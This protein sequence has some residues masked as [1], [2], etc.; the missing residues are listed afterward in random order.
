MIPGFENACKKSKFQSKIVQFTNL[1]GIIKMLTFGNRQ[2]RS[3]CLIK[4]GAKKIATNV[5]RLFIVIIV[6]HSLVSLGSEEGLIDLAPQNR[7]S[8]RQGPPLQVHEFPHTRSQIEEG[9]PD[10]SD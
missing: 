7:F 2:S 6:R 4:N 5:T 10:P 3:G 1:A 8:L 9:D